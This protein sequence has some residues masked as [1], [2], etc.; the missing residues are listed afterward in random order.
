MRRR[1][2]PA[3]AL[4][5]LWVHKISPQASDVLH[6]ELLC[7][8]HFFSAYPQIP[9]DPQIQNARWVMSETMHTDFRRPPLSGYAFFY[10]NHTA[11][12]R[13][14][15]LETAVAEFAEFPRFELIFLESRSTSTGRRFYRFEYKIGQRSAATITPDAGESSVI[16]LQHAKTHDQFLHLTCRP[17]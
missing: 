15:L 4:A 3:I 17:A 10:R 14:K 6:R 7:E 5:C 9:Q 11:H 2:I 1:K 16:F 12:W 8:A 13:L